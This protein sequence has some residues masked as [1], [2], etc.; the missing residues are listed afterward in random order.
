MEGVSRQRHPLGPA[1]SLGANPRPAT[2]AGLAE[3]FRDR[4]APMVRL[5]TMLTDSRETAEEIVMEAFAQLTPRFGTLDEPGAYLRTSVV[6]GSRS[7]LRRVRTVRRHPQ[8]P[9]GTTSSPEV[10]E[11]WARLTSLRPD[12]RSCVVLRFYEDLTVDQIAEVLDMRS[13]TVKSHLHRA[14]A[15]LRDL[16]PEEDR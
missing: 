5:A 9:A 15:A 13:N 2:V 11:L 4:F 14:I 1:P 7:H 3:L 10:D 12:E 16:V 8:P 6:N